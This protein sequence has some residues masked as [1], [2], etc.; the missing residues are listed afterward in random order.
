MNPLQQMVDGYGAQL[1][2]ERSQSQMTLGQLID[3]LEAMPPDQPVA[4]LCEPHSYRGYYC[5]LAF[6]C[7]LGGRMASDVLTMCQECMGEVFTGWKGG[8]FQMG[9][10]TPIWVAFEGHL[11]RK[12]TGLEP[13]GKLATADDD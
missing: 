8:E 6:E 12:I 11:G 2:R 13:N 5:D 9:R 3:V 7:V 4:G 1:Q 10:N